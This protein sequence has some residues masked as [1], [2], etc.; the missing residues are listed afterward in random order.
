ML[1][2]D[3]ESVLL[4]TM[5]LKPSEQD[6]KK[7]SIVTVQSSREAVIL[8]TGFRPRTI[9]QYLF[10]LMDLRA[11][12][13][14]KAAARNNEDTNVVMKRKQLKKIHDNLGSHAIES[15]YLEVDAQGD[16]RPTLEIY[17]VRKI[18]RQIRRHLFPDEAEV[19]YFPPSDW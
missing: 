3:I 16:E 18:Q 12:R 7:K 15:R 4:K 1:A 5:E 17:Q 13:D 6:P 11:G 10:Q 2:R 8:Q 14:L 19:L 9:G